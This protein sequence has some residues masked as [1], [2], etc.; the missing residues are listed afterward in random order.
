MGLSR[1]IV[2]SEWILWLCTGY[3]YLDGHV[4]L[5]VWARANRII[6]RANLEQ[7]GWL[8]NRFYN[9]GEFRDCLRIFLTDGMRKFGKD[10]FRNCL[11]IFLVEE[12]GKFG[13]DKFWNCLVMFLVEEM[14]KFGK[15]K[16]WNCLVIFQWWKFW[17]EIM[18]RA[19]RKRVSPRGSRLVN[20]RERTNK[21]RAYGVYIPSYGAIEWSSNRRAPGDSSVCCRIIWSAWR[22]EEWQIFRFTEVLRLS[23]NSTWNI[24]ADERFAAKSEFDWEIFSLMSVLR[25]SQN[26][27]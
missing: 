19:K 27:T 18:M 14:R 15:D 9:K 16:L 7:V 10:R 26:S 11:R 24:F 12:M 2:A 22:G 23:Q 5:L 8:Y 17:I 1:W 6:R 3:L 25:L 4:S 21:M 13:K 20:W